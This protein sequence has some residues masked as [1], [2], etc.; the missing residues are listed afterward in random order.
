MAL[1]AMF[2]ASVLICNLQP[3]ST[4]TFKVLALVAAL[5]S[6]VMGIMAIRFE[7]T[8]SGRWMGTAAA[9]VPCIMYLVKATILAA[10][11]V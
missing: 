7:K 11:K 8:S 5:S 9:C 4:E 3:D 6:S 10:E 1:A 2:V